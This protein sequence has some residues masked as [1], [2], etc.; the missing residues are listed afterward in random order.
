MRLSSLCLTAVLLFSSVVFAQHHDSSAPS[1]PPPSP[2]PSAAPS[3]APTPAPSAPPSFS[4]SAAPSSSSS[5]S[6]SH[7]S[8]P[9]SSPSPSTSASQVPPSAASATNHLGDSNISRPAV[10]HAPASEPERVI[11]AQKLAA[12][13]QNRSRRTRRGRFAGKRTRIETRG[14]RPAPQDLRGRGL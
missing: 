12:R 6:I 10:A 5:V 2:A 8:A 1:N 3:P 13:G 4:T 14:A 7:S 9:S 11:P